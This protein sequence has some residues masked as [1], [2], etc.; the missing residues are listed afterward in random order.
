M[1]LAGPDDTVSLP[2]LASLA[3]EKTIAFSWLYPNQWPK[4][5]RLLSTGVI[6]TSKLI[7]HSGPL[8]GITDAIG[9]VSRRDDGVIKYMVRPGG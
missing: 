4:T 7:T 9:H 3:Q 2:M 1:G 6:D 5:I 8:D